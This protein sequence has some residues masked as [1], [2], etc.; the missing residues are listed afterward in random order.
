VRSTALEQAG[1]YKGALIYYKK[2]DMLDDSLQKEDAQK[3]INELQIKYKT[4]EKERIMERQKEEIRQKNV[5]LHF[6]VC[7]VLA[8]IVI[9]FITNRYRRLVRRRNRELRSINNMKDKFFS[10][11]S[12]DLKNPVLAQ[13]NSLAALVN[14]FGHME[15]SD[16]HEICIELLDSS[17]SLLDLLYN[18]LSW[19]RLQ[20]GRIIYTPSPFPLIDVVREVENLTNVQL[21]EKS[22]TL[23]VTIPVDATVVADRNMIS[24]V[25]RNLIS[26][27]IKFSYKGGTID[28]S[29]KRNETDWCVS[30]SD[31]GIGMSPEVKSSLFNIESQKLMPGTN[32]ETGSGLGLAVCQE[33]LE[34][35]GSNICVN[36]QE[37]K[38]SE[39]S[40]SLHEG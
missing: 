8:C 1:D 7:G 5:M 12:H 39:F 14:N 13:K 26:N 16:I 19:S 25:M 27:A 4:A 24:T 32:G 34:M 9:I 23:N 33:M 37:G 20:T 22:L 15:S 30:V 29:A 10:V 36:T 38:G 2:M 40:F 21:N 17:K 3:Q 31:K 18:L 28:I 35:H 11:I 6:L